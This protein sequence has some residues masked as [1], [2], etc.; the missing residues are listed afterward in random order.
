MGELAAQ[1]DAASANG[2]R[3]PAEMEAPADE[4]KGDTVDVVGVPDMRTD[5]GE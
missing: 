1:E 3:P 4:F 5:E 2:D